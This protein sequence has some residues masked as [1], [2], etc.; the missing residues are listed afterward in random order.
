MT[1]PIRPGM[2][3]PLPGPLHS[4]RDKLAELADLGYTDIWSAES[5]GADGFTPLALAAQQAAD[6]RVGPTVLD[7]T[8]TVRFLDVERYQAT[9]EG[10][11]PILLSLGTTGTRAV[12]PT[13]GF[14]VP[15]LLDPSQAG[16]T[17]GALTATVQWNPQR[18]V[19]DS[20]TSGTLGTVQTN[21]APTSGTVSLS[22]F[23]TQGTATT[24]TVATLYFRTTAAVGGTTIL[25][26]PTQIGDLGGVSRLG[27]ALARPTQACVTPP[28][29][30]G[31]VNGDGAVN[32]I[33]AQQVARRTV[34][35]SVLRPSLVTVQGDVNGDAVADITLLV[36]NAVPPD[37]SWFVL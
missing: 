7:Q 34:D 31:D 33:D 27:Q 2:T 16:A 22:V 5:D 11:G 30:W 17:I 26:T 36:R 15:V 6:P 8:A 9:V 18:L 23:S 13:E 3:V 1:L 37:A 20:V 29:K 12:V 14:A 21:I 28:G 24:A 35:L 32:V 25:L 19:L 4:H 10:T